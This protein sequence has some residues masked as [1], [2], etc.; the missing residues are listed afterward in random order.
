MN[1]QEDTKAL[2]LAHVLSCGGNGVF[3]SYFRALRAQGA[4]AL[5]FACLHT[6]PWCVPYVRRD[7]HALPM[8]QRLQECSQ[9]P[10]SDA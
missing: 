8:R 2:V 4:S 10:L 1:T 7:T 3:R 9:P 6:V 5:A